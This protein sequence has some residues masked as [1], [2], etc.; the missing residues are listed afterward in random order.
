MVSSCNDLYSGS[1]GVDS[2]FNFVKELRT[3][4]SKNWSVFSSSATL[5]TLQNS[6]T[7][8]YSKNTQIKP[9]VHGRFLSFKDEDFCFWSFKNK[10]LP[11]A[12]SKDEDFYLS[13]TVF[14]IHHVYSQGLSFKDER[15]NSVVCG[16]RTTETS[17]RVSYHC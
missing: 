3:A 16:F 4:K 11:S 5:F 9:T 13:K 10:N 15:L 1:S 12:V 14:E 7:V 2:I 6:F 17:Q 8:A